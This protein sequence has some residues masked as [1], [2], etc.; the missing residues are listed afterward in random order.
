M[1]VQ[2]VNGYNQIMLNPLKL[3][4]GCNI[5]GKNLG[6]KH[7]F[8]MCGLLPWFWFPLPSGKFFFI[9]FYK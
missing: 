9:H 5:L 2:G 1:H 8:A 4:T 3:L 7:E 6:I